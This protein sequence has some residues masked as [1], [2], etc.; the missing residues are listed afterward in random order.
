MKS[1][2]VWSAI[3]TLAIA[4]LPV[5]NE[6]L[7]TGF[8]RRRLFQIFLVFTTTAGTIAS[9]SVASH[10]LYTPHGLPGRNYIREEDRVNES[11]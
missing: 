8:T 3:L 1:K 7:E 6:G 11:S 9:R 4:T 5:V 10:Q 2:T